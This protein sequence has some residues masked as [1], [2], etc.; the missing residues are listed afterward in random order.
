MATRVKSPA[1]NHEQD[2]LLVA[3][4]VP[5]YY[6]HTHPEPGYNYLKD[7]RPGS[8]REL[9]APQVDFK[10]GGYAYPRYQDGKEVFSK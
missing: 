7:R 4:C 9:V 10:Q 3:D 5:A 2:T 1:A 8:Y 6:G